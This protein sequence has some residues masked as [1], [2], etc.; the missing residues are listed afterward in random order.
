ML[1][2]LQFVYQISMVVLFSSFFVKT[3]SPKKEDGKA[4]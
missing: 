1:C 3:F 2:L 4:L